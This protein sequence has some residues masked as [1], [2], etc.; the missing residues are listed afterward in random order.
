V[1]YSWQASEQTPVTNSGVGLSNQVGFTWN[2]TGTKL[3][4]VSANN[5]IGM[6]AT[7]TSIMISQ[8]ITTPPPNTSSL[9]ITPGQLNFAA[10]AGGANPAQQTLSIAH[11]GTGSVSWLASDD[12][13]WLS[14]SNSSG[15]VPADI[16]VTVDTTG[17]VAGT[18]QGTIAITSSGAVNS[19]QSVN[20][21]LI[22]TKP[23][24][25]L[26]PTKLS[27]Q[28]IQGDATP[29][30]QSVNISNIGDG[31]LNW[32]ANET[33]PWLELSKSSGT[34]PDTIIVTA[35][36]GNL[37]PTT[38]TGQIAFINQAYGTQEL[39]DVTL[40]VKLAG[41]PILQ[42]S[43]SSLMFNAKQGEANPAAQSFT[44]GNIGVGTLNWTASENLDWLSLD[45]TSG[46][47]P[48]FVEASVDISKLAAKTYSGQIIVTSAE[49]ITSS[50]QAVNVTLIVAAQKS[51]L[52]VDCDDLFF[53]AQT[54]GENPAPLQCTIDSVEGVPLAWQI[55]E[56]LSWLTMTTISGTSPSTIT[57]AVDIAGLSQGLYTGQ[58]IF[59]SPGAFQTPQAFDVILAVI[60]PQRPPKLAI[61]KGGPPIVTPGKPITYTLTII[62][63]GHFTASGLIITDTMPVG[64]SY[65]NGG[66]LKSSDKVVWNVN[67]L[68]PGQVTKVTYAITAAGVVTNSRYQVASKGNYSATGRLHV[69][70]KMTTGAE[71]S[72]LLQGDDHQQ[73]G[74]SNAR[75][76]ALGDLNGD[77]YL[78]VFIVNYIQSQR[79]NGQP[80][81]VWLNDGSGKL[82]DTKQALGESPGTA[83]ALADVDN[84]GDFD[85]FVTN[86]LGHHD[87][88]WLNDG[89][90]IF[91]D[92]GQELGQTESQG[93]ALGDVNGDGEI[94]AIVVNENQANVIWL[95]DG[96]GKFNSSGQDLGVA[97]GQAVAL[98][99][100]NSDGVLDVIVGNGSNQADKI[101]LNDGSGVFTETQTVG[102]SDTQAMALG[103]LNNDGAVDLFVGNGSAEPDQVWFNDGS[104]QFINTGQSL[105]NGDGNAVV[106]GDLDQDGDLD[107]IVGNDD[108]RDTIL[109][110]DGSG[111]FYDNSQGINTNQTQSIGLGD[112]DNDG[113]LDTFVVS[114]GQGN[115]LLLNMNQRVTT[116][117][118]TT[119]GQISETT[120]DITTTINIPA[121]ALKA[122]TDLT[123]TALISVAHPIPTNLHFVGKGFRLGAMQNGSQVSQPFNQPITVTFDIS[124]TDRLFLYYW[125][126]NDETWLD[127]ATTCT[128]VSKY[129]RTGNRLL[130]VPLC[131][132]TEFALFEVDAVVETHPAVYL[133]IVLK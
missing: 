81:E 11:T 40:A 130:S 132:L 93:V 65:L 126:E 42:L 131:H 15:L 50:P 69:V 60:D 46:T 103:D 7:T 109:L 2:T 89:Q 70:T 25:Q 87:E 96:S 55:T 38:Y 91:T 77:G 121:G 76:V 48:S 63:S 78:D 43:P 64:A 124:A 10:F 19:S 125:D 59:N 71:S 20:V 118:A 17:L 86:E 18:Y 83:V 75:S 14:L 4:T 27:F 36:I 100:V 44:I 80:N 72:G 39:V 97:D 37:P 85:A 49:A 24:L 120:R 66:T 41:N 31:T 45:Q 128:P 106:L 116:F 111:Y 34:A 114:N 9:T 129:L 6:V 73:L 21:N 99:D 52:Q 53:Q 13:A 5:S 123:Y 122:Q 95:N 8:V 112:F 23:I 115:Q 32:Q 119:D 61:S 54:G 26:S 56:S 33:L 79:S 104:G 28:G 57:V 110:N 117:E 94:D 127:V 47:A 133:P 68:P 98:G 84:D 62:N 102:S 107:A 30:M 74:K 88:L 12:M 82:V 92:S 58:L 67:N 101:W 35:T 16:F 108:G 29:M 1:T 113:D 3:I 105:G 51:T 90:G 22:V